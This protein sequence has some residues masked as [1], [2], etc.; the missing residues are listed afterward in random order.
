MCH[1]RDR[2][3][4]D[5][6]RDN[7]DDHRCHVSGRVT[8]VRD[9]RR[10]Q[11]NVGKRS[12]AHHSHSR[13]RLWGRS[14]SWRGCG[15]PSCG[16]RGR[17]QSVWDGGSSTGG[18]VGFRWVHPAKVDDDGVG[19]VWGVNVS[20]PQTMDHPPVEDAQSEH[21]DHILDEQEEEDSVESTV[22]L[23]VQQSSRLVVRHPVVESETKQEIVSWLIGGVWHV[24]S[25][26]HNAAPKNRAACVSYEWTR[27]KGQGF[28][29][30]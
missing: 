2:V 18:S 21:R 29:L 28:Y 4:D 10:V 23:T 3:T 9:T 30:R 27:C 1:C 6:Q 11:S 14:P 13:G 15:G 5:T 24:G 20:F 19:L 17:G 7:H 26:T 8:W 22:D 16:C 12:G 25:R